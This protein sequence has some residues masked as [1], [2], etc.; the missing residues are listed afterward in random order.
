MTEH[1]DPGPEDKT[2]S[3]PEN[4]PETPPS[5]PEEVSKN[6]QELEDDPLERAQKE[7]G[8]AAEFDLEAQIEEFRRQA[9]GEPDN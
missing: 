1:P 9:E 6:F 4:E 3:S 5:V 8:E 2:E 7:G